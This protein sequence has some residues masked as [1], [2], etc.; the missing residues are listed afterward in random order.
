MDVN[1]DTYLFTLPISQIRT[2]GESRTIKLTILPLGENRLVW[3]W[4]CRGESVGEIDS[5]GRV[6]LVMVGCEEG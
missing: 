5:R 3:K 2:L 4:K 1:Y 6:V